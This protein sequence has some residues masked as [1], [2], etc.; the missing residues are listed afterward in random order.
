MGI[1]E[2]E[3]CEEEEGINEQRNSAKKQKIWGLFC[4]DH[5]IGGRSQSEQLDRTFFR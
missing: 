1:Y 2:I 5:P 4:Y 3:R